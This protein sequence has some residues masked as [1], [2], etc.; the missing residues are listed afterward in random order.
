MRSLLTVDC[1]TRM[2][3][4]DVHKHTWM[5]DFPSIRPHWNGES[6]GKYTVKNSLP[7][8]FRNVWS[9]NLCSSQIESPYPRPLSDG[10]QL[11]V[12]AAEAEEG[13]TQSAEVESSSS[14]KKTENPSVNGVNLSPSASCNS[15]S[16]YQSL[17]SNNHAVLETSLHQPIAASNNSTGARNSSNISPTTNDLNVPGLTLDHSD[18]V[19][20]NASNASVSASK[21]AGNESISAGNLIGGNTPVNASKSSTGNA[22]LTDKALT[23]N[24]LVTDKAL[25]GNTSVTDKALTGNTI[26]CSS[27]APASHVCNSTTNKPHIQSGNAT[28]CTAASHA[29][30]ASVCTEAAPADNASVGSKQVAKVHVSPENRSLSSL[31]P[32]IDEITSSSISANRD[33]NNASNS[34]SRKQKKSKMS[35]IVTKIRVLP[36]KFVTILKKRLKRAK[37]SK[38]NNH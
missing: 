9:L 15:P 26:A 28:V 8:Y 25:T 27:N 2:K 22:S 37:S 14:A 33:L 17:C 24:T 30:K 29:G 3:V 1:T 10:Q 19:S 38:Q 21:P 12:D 13:T 6:G 31:Y 32:S 18:H 7:Y 36:K 11:I 16:A 4:A 23:G 20:V 5:K 34:A 35:R